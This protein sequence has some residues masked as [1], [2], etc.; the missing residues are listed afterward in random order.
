MTLTCPKFPDFTNRS[1]LRD[2]QVTQWC[3]YFLLIQR[4]LSLNPDRGH[5]LTICLWQQ[6]VTASFMVEMRTIK[7]LPAW[8]PAAHL[9]PDGQ[10]PNPGACGQC[11]LW[12]DGRKWMV[13][14][15]TPDPKPTW[16]HSKRMITKGTVR[17]YKVMWVS[18]ATVTF[19]CQKK[20]WA[21]SFKNLD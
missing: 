10:V 18:H 5:R 19:K 15:G 17:F 14:E 3:Q 6:Q 8:Q 16:S 7:V 21:G 11:P 20:H 2:V 4:K 13:S 12:E 9:F 1:F